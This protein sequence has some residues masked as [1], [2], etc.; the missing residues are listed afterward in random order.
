MGLFPSS[1]VDWRAYKRSHYLETHLS[2]RY[3]TEFAIRRSYP[4]S[5]LAF[6]IMTLGTRGYVVDWRPFPIVSLKIA[7]IHWMLRGMEVSSRA[8]ERNW[9]ERG[10]QPSGFQ[11]SC[12]DGDEDLVSWYASNFQCLLNFELSTNIAL[13]LKRQK[14]HE[15][16]LV[17]CSKSNYSK[18]T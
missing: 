7:Y 12:K 3:Q 2:V 18:Q 9:S 10:W 13:Y 11:S 17:N 15:Y 16:I 1:W 5:T 8:T 6:Q 14:K 4:D